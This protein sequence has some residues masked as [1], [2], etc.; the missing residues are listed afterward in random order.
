MK[1]T[2]RR[3]TSLLGLVAVLSGMIVIGGASPALADRCEPTEL[4]VRAVLPGYEEPVATGD[5]PVCYT[6]INYVYP[7]V[8]DDFSTLMNCTA[9]INPDPL[10]EPVTVTPYQPEPGRIYCNTRVF[11]VGGTCSYDPIWP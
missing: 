5:S 9:S 10:S 4:V 8:C 6:L 3:L 11:A 2:K 7:R 1:R